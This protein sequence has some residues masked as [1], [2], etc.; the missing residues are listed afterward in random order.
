MCGKSIQLQSIPL[1]L[2]LLSLLHEQKRHHHYCCRHRRP[3]SHHP[4]RCGGAYRQSRWSSTPLNFILLVDAVGWE[5]S[6][7]CSAADL[8]EPGEARFG[9]NYL[10]EFAASRGE[11]TLAALVTCPAR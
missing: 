3:N 6:C 8:G 11:R 7:Q 4:H 5:P 9:L 2:L 10:L 1:W